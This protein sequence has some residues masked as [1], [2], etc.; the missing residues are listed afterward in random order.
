MTNR[1]LNDS[2]DRFRYFLAVARTGT[3]AEAAVQLG[4]EHTTV[5]RHIR[6]LEDML[7]NQ[8]FHRSNQGYQLTEAGQRLLSTAEAM[9]SAVLSAKAAAADEQQIAGTVRVGATDGFGAI[10]LAPRVGALTSLHPMLNLEIVAA[11][12]I[13]SLSKREADIVIGLA[14]PEQSRIV[15][16]RLTDYNLFVYGSRAYLDA[17]PA[18]FTAEDL[19]A[20]PIISY[21]EELVNAPQLD[22]LSAIV[23]DIEARIRTTGTFPQIYAA[24]GGAGLCILPAYVGSSFPTLIPV[25]PEKI[26]LTRSYHMHIHEDHRK[27]PHVRAVASFIA[28][29]VEKNPT[30]FHNPAP[31]SSSDR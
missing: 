31:P 10:F 30:L 13:F 21:V 26:S 11:P 6:M 25:F 18:I 29:E 5:G 2:W 15:S 24:L 17:A 4:T 1:Q 8:L 3:L 19:R 27:A 28:A 23:P 20:H 16:R 14:V 12:R 22:Y 9:E 7:K